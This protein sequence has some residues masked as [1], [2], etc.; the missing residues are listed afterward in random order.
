[1]H[2]Q[3]PYKKQ[4]T[5]MQLVSWFFYGQRLESLNHKIVWPVF[6]FD[7]FLYGHPMIFMFFSKI[8]FGNK[9]QLLVY[10]VSSPSKVLKISRHKGI[11]HQ[12]LSERNFSSFCEERKTFTFV[13]VCPTLH[14]CRLYFS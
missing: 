12:R 14:H 7:V 10:K 6:D 3:L 1:M 8:F 4:L 2:H 13:V 5:I 11:S 9:F